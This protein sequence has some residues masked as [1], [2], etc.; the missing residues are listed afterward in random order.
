MTNTHLLALMA[1]L[2]YRNSTLVRSMPTALHTWK[3][4]AKAKLVR[5]H[6]SRRWQTSHLPN[7][8][9]A[10]LDHVAAHCLDFFEVA[11]HLVVQLSKPVCNPVGGGRC[12]KPGFNGAAGAGWQGM[13][14]SQRGEG[15]RQG[16]HPST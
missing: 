6:G 8:A 9:A 5:H 1:S 4:I 10:H 7:W 14:P 12:A 15:A 3:R 2:E 13:V 11:A 16:A